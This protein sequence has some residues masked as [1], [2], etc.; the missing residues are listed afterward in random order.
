MGYTASRSNALRIVC[1][2]LKTVGREDQDAIIC[3]IVGASLWADTVEMI[4]RL[5]AFLHQ[6]PPTPRRKKTPPADPKASERGS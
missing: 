3:A 5:D 1:G 2:G 4:E 6:K